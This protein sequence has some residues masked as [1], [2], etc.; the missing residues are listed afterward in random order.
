MGTFHL[1]SVFSRPP[2][3]AEID[4]Q[5]HDAKTKMVTFMAWKQQKGIP[6]IILEH[7]GVH[8]SC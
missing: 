4:I 5:G 1:N 2:L 6:E 3:A 8:P 7:L